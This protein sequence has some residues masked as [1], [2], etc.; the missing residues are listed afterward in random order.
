[1][2]PSIDRRTLLGAVAAGSLAALAGCSSSCPDSGSPDPDALVDASD[3]PAGAFSTVPGGTWRA[4]RVDPANTGYAPDIAPPE[5][6]LGVRWRRS[7]STERIEA[8]SHRASAPAVADGRVVVA[9]PVGV[10]A[11][12]LRD[13]TE[14]WQTTDATPNTTAATYGYD[15][16]VVPPVVGPEGTVYVGTAEGLVALEPSDGSERWR[17]DDAGAVRTPVATE[18]AVYVPAGTDLVAV[19]P[20]DGS[21]RWTAAVGVE[22]GLPAVGSDTV[23]VG[24]G[25]AVAV[26]AA[27]GEERWRVGRDADYYPVVAGDTVYLGGYEGLRALSVASGEERWLFERG[28]GRSLSP[29]VVTPESLYVVESPGEAGD[30]TFALDRTDGAP[31]PRWCSDVGEGAVTAAT[32][33]RA[34]GL[35]PGGAVPGES[36][37]PVQLVAYDERFGNAG[38]GYQTREAV[39]PP[40]VLDG[41]VVAVGVDGQVVAVGA[42]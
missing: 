35:L 23:V 11:L 6:P 34:F 7:L 1:M 30:A 38:W 42:V 19:D 21:E 32:E 3:D 26:A 37:P 40:A 36:G 25:E 28:S 27:S 10:T 24:Q 4:P 41:A 8:T 12:S 22:A 13:G 9:T 29:P 31:E 16:E 39:L 17:Y 33:E 14:L 20:A 15:E 18:D 2:T 5:P